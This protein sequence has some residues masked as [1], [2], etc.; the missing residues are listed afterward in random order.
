MSKAS[1]FAIVT[2]G[3]GNAPAANLHRRFASPSRSAPI[4]QPLRLQL[5]QALVNV[6]RAQS[7]PPR[8]ISRAKS[9]STEREQVDDSLLLAIDIQVFL[10]LAGIKAA[11]C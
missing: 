1:S 7:S 11:F 4:D 9:K 5:Q 2:L 8:D 6:A 3:W 10:F